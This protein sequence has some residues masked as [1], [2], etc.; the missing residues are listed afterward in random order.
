M[1][2]ERSNPSRKLESW[3]VMTWYVPVEVL[4]IKNSRENATCDTESVFGVVI[5][6]VLRKSRPSVPLS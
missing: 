4:L 3:L 2:P 5:N 1:P 6:S